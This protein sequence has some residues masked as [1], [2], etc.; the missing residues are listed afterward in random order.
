MTPAK[1][2]QAA[3][4][5]NLR[6]EGGDRKPISFTAAGLAALVKLQDRNGG[7]LSDQ[8]NAALIAAARALP[9]APRGPKK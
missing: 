3:W 5:A 9:R 4:L 7:T 8:V 1:D 2:R 6:A